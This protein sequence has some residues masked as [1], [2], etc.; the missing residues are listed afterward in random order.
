MRDSQGQPG[1]H[2][3][4]P[5]THSD[6]TN[7]GAQAPRGRFPAHRR[8]EGL[9]RAPRQYQV[10]TET[11]ERKLHSRGGSTATTRVRRPALQMGQ[12]GGLGPVDAMRRARRPRQAARRPSATSYEDG[13]APQMGQDPDAQRGGPTCPELTAGLLSASQG[14]K[15]DEGPPG[16]HRSPVCSLEDGLCLSR[17]VL[18]WTSQGLCVCVG[19]PIPRPHPT[20]ACKGSQGFEGCMTMS[21]LSSLKVPWDDEWRN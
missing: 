17:K 20:E 5:P 1:G 2:S 12:E 19:G 9:S 14:Q 6:V 10:G 18:S 13:M 3:H 4:A 15:G 21:F 8:R 7:V 16:T 11:K